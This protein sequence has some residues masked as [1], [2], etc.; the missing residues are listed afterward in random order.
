MLSIKKRMVVSFISIILLGGCGFTGK[1]GGN[2]YVR[3]RI[4]QARNSG[5]RMVMRTTKLLREAE[6]K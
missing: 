1:K 5:C 2:S 3:V 6:R 4:T